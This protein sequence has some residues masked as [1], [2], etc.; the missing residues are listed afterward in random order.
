M[1]RYVDLESEKIAKWEYGELRM[2]HIYEFHL[3]IKLIVVFL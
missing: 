1:L 2:S 3:E